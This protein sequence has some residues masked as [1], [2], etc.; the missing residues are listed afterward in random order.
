MSP[1]APG[2]VPN[3][4]AAALDKIEALGSPAAIADYFERRGITGYRE[5]S[6]KCPVA[7][8]LTVETGNP[9][10]V[11]PGCATENRWETHRD[12]PR[13]FVNLGPNVVGFIRAYDAGE[14]VSLERPRFRSY[15]FVA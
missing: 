8:Y 2:I 14:F 5:S 15:D 3:T 4:T 1:Y 6:A 9:H 11:G 10:L 13:E 12:Q 7:V